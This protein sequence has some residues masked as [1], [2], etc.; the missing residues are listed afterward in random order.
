MDWDEFHA[1]REKLGRPFVIGH[2]GA[3]KRE[4]ENTLRSFAHTLKLG[5][6]VLETDLRFTRDEQIVLI[7]DETVDRTTDGQGS[8]RDHLLRDLKQLRTRRPEDNRPSDAPIPT[9]VELLA[10]T[11][12]ETPL[13]LELKDN[14][15]AGRRYAQKLIDILA[16]YGML[17]RVAIISFQQALV[18]SVKLVYPRLAAGY[19]TLNDPRPPRDAEL[20]GPFW[21]LLV[22][23]PFYVRDVHRSGGI[24]AP[25]DPNPLPRLSLYLR[26]GVDAL[27]ADEPGEVIEALEK[28]AI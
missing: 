7:H 5:A 2:R 6:D 26:L 1:E 21:P 27:L 10:M 4:P 25:L 14:R 24:I 20:A 16:Y 19:V 28:R 12:A 17:S 18:R 22:L 15:F 11:Q 23:N 8:V 3:P 9:L 13:L